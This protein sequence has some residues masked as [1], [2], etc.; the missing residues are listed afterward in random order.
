[1]VI[2][3]LYGYRPYT[4]AFQQ[5]NIIAPLGATSKNTG[6][7]GLLWISILV[8]RVLQLSIRP[9]TNHD[10]DN[11]LAPRVQ[12]AAPSTSP[13][14]QPPKQRSFMLEGSFYVHTTQK[15]FSISEETLEANGNTDEYGVYQKSDGGQSMRVLPRSWWNSALKA[16][17]QSAYIC[18]GVRLSLRS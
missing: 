5:S 16:S 8:G 3:D 17:I 11:R 2:I 1:M 13:W 14:L 15:V 7:A 4:G 6:R 12:L 18:K 10:I 9:Q